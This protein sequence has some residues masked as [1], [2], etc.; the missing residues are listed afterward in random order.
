[1]YTL[2]AKSKD[3]ETSPLAQ[4]RRVYEVLNI[5][6]FTEI[7][8]AMQAYLTSIDD[9]QKNKYTIDDSVITKVNQHWQFAFDEWDYTRLDPLLQE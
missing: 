7:K 4:V 1:M 9:Y 6:G 5:S 8:P 2:E 3:L